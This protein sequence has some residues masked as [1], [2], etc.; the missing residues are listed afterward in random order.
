MVGLTKT[1][2]AEVGAISRVRRVLDASGDAVDE[3]VLVSAG[4]SD[5]SEAAWVCHEDEAPALGSLV[6]VSVEVV[7]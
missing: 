6:R 5:C 4:R 3:L 2:L 1:F 7:A